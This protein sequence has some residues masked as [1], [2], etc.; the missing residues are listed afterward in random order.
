[1]T[2]TTAAIEKDG[3]PV[4][5]SSNNGDGDETSSAE[6][7]QESDPSILT[8]SEIGWAKEIKSC[9]MKEDENLAK[10]ITDL[11]Y[12][13]LAIITKGKLDRAIK[14]VHRLST[15]KKEHG[16]DTDGANVAADDIT[17]L[18]DKAIE[19][20]KNLEKKSPNFIMSFGREDDDDEDGKESKNK[21]SSVIAFNLTAFNPRKYNIKKS[22]SSDTDN[23]DADADANADSSDTDTDDAT[24]KEWKILYTGLYYLFEASSSTIANIR[25]GTDIICNCDVIG[26]DN[27]SNDITKYGSSLY[28]DSYP[29]RINGINCVNTPF[30]FRAIYAICKPFVSVH[31]TK[32]LNMSGTV[33]QI[34]DTYSPQILP[35]SFDGTLGSWEMKNKLTAALKLRYETKATFTL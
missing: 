30:I 9:I 19:S 23:A 21:T 18:I 2:S 6:E 8:Q 31:T 32:V 25:A 13:Q 3:I 29:I 28:Q 5:L 34:Q 27:Y 7:E 26:Y 20:I 12:G 24:A 16:I 11:E 4:V 10:T 1:M 35:K 17:I 33:Q 14:M 22:S 15:F